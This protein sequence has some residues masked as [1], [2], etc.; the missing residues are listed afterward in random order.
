MHLHPTT[1]DSMA[2]QTRLA[3]TTRRW[4]FGQL[5]ILLLIGVALGV[6]GMYML[7]AAP[8]RAGAPKPG[9]PDHIAALQVSF[10]QDVL[11]VER[12]EQQCATNAVVSSSVKPQNDVLSVEWLERNRQGTPNTPPFGS[13]AQSVPDNTI[14]FIE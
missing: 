10:G 13:A 12:L 6:F 8:A 9:S 4:S 1:E 14:G 5:S 3:M 11:S 7:Q 2:T